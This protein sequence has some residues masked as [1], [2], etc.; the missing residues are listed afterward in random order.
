MKQKFAV[1]ELILSALFAA[2]TAVL[3]QI[4]LPIGPVPF[5]LGVFGAYLAGMMLSPLWA[6]A[7]MAVYMLMGAV[8]VPVFAGFMAG[9]TAL[10][11]PTGGYIIAYLFMAVL[12]SVAA[13]RTE[14][15]AP[16]AAAMLLGLLICYALGTAWFMIVTGTDLPKALMS[17][18]VPF[19]IPDLAKAAAALWLGRQLSKR[20]RKA[21]VL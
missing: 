17:C 13:H 10:F 11:G 9:P 18:V 7:S 14:K 2:L 15:N 4:R 3:S 8:G 12:T 6:G 16:A 1:K 21:G 5:N 20:M 19:V